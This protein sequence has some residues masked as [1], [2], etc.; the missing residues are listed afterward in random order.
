[1]GLAT[2]VPIEEYLSRSWDPDREYVDG[3]LVEKNVGEL[4]HSHLQYLMAKLLD[5]RGLRPL[6]ELRVQVRINRFRI[7]DVSAVRG[8]RPSGRFLRQPPFV[9]VEILSRDDRAS[10][11]DDK[12]DDYL[13]FGVENIWVVDPRRLRVSVRTKEGS[14]ICVEKVESTDGSISIPLSEIFADIPRQED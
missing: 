5:Q 13:D 11:I 8:A 6:V 14:R 3:R 12:I 2:L 10:D 9:V 7:P 1:M 4:D